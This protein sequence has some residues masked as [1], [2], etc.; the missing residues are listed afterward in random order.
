MVR[1][2]PQIGG[3]SGPVAQPSKRIVKSIPKTA[4]LLKQNENAKSKG[5]GKEK[6]VLGGLSGL[7]DGG[8][9][10]QSRGKVMTT[11]ATRSLPSAVM[12]DKLVETRALEILAFR[13]AMASAA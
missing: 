9:Q 5:K 10:M 4:D 1:S 13:N 8:L 12:I 3:S 7:M 2:K 6:E 11:V